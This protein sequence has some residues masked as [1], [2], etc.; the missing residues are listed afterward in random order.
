MWKMNRILS[1]FTLFMLG[2]LNLQ[3]REVVGIQFNPSD[4]LVAFGAADLKASLVDSVETVVYFGIVLTVMRAAVTLFLRW[5]S[6]EKVAAKD[7]APGMIL[8]EKAWE[9]MRDF[10]RDHEEKVPGK[11]ADGLF[12]EDVAT[13]RSWK[14][15]PDFMV[16]VYRA[17]PFAFWVFYGTLMTLVLPKNAVYWLFRIIYDPSG[18]VLSFLRLWG[19]GV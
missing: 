5:E 12:P 16:T 17:T 13:L 19:I 4:L 14:K 3:A 18:A 1:G 15:L 9:A 7:L 10:G 2:G 6:A 11:Y 8:S